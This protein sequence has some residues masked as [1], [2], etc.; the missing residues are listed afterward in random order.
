MNRN[1][2]LATSMVA[3]LAGFAAS[4]SAQGL[5]GANQFTVYGGGSSLA[6]N[7]YSRTAGAISTAKNVGTVTTVTDTAFPAGVTI[8]QG[9]NT[10]GA[11]AGTSSMYQGELYYNADG[12]GKGQ[13]AFLT[14]LPSVHGI[15]DITPVHFGASDAYLDQS[16]I[17]C[18]NGGSTCGTAA[19]SSPRH[20]RAHRG[21][22]GRSPPPGTVPG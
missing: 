4:A 18:W 21:G 11:I 16:Q 19:T 15:T 20:R 10:P 13:K 2:L 12:S 7:M 6:V 1:F 5:T 22:G 17:D 9:V 14:Q 8:P 3:G